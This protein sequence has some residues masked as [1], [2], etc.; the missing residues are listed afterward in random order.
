MDA[1]LRYGCLAAILVAILIADTRFRSVTKT[2]PELV[3]AVP[4][5]LS[6]QLSRVRRVSFTVLQAEMQIKYDTI[7]EGKAAEVGSQKA[8]LKLPTPAEV[9][10]WL[11]RS[12]TGPLVVTD[13]PVRDWPAMRLWYN[14]TDK[15][16]PYEYMSRHVQGNFTV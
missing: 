13:S 4:W 3:A 5:Q 2:P 7:A 14:K 16:N 15:N 9:F 1:K 6:S 12:R 8:S 10:E 11:A